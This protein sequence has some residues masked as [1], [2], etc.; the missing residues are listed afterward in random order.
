MFDFTKAMERL[1]RH[2]VEVCPEFAH[3]QPD[4]LIIAHIRTRSPGTHGVYASVQPLRFEGGEPTIMKRGRTFAMPQVMHC[5]HEILYIIYFALPRFINL[6]YEEKLTTVFHELYH[7]SPKFNGDIRR[8]KG[9]N[10]A[11]GHSRKVYNEKMQTFVNNYMSKPATDEYTEFL[12]M[13]FEKMS[14]EYGRIIGTK[15]K[16]PRPRLV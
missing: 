15:V 5:G 6:S 7:I 3:V 16:P 13:D 8:F 4:N 11:H 12:K 9:K 10:F 14:A 2:I 1:V